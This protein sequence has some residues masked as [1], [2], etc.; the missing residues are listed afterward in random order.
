[1]EVEPPTDVGGHMKPG[2]YILNTSFG[3]DE[4]LLWACCQLGL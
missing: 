2:K 3:V 1:M 4:C